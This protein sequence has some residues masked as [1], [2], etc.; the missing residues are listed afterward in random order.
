MSI[1]LIIIRSK[2]KELMCME[3][4][5]LSGVWY[6]G[7]SVLVSS[8]AQIIRSNSVLQNQ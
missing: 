7:L 5:I 4:V 2:N 3:C 6:V 1:S 8:L